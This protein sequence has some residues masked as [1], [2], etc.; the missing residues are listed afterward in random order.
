M[1]RKW[2]IRI[3]IVAVGVFVL[4]WAAWPWA[5]QIS[6]LVPSEKELHSYMKKAGPVEVTLLQQYGLLEKDPGNREYVDEIVKQ[7]EELLALNQYYWVDGK[8]QPWY[9]AFMYTIRG[10]DQPAAYL[11]TWPGPESLEGKE[12]LVAQASDTATLMV[13]AWGM[14]EAGN[15]VASQM[16]TTLGDSSPVTQETLAST[17]P[18]VTE[19][20]TTKGD[21][22]FVYKRWKGNYRPPLSIFR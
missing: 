9:R 8:K 11:P 14:K 22:D 5:S 1:V 2:L 13:M 12:M 3:F 18:V 16:L 7:S 15:A 19:A 17:G 10:M 6:W 20:R 21:A 4:L